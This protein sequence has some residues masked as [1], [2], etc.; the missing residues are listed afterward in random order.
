MTLDHKIRAAERQLFARYGLQPEESFLDVDSVRN[1]AAVL[2]V[3]QK[4]AAGAAARR[5]LR[6]LPCGHPG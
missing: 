5:R 6:L 3:E 1:S 4:L 2:S